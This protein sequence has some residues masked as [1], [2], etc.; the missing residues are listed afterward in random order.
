MWRPQ[1]KH[2]ARVAAAL[3]PLVLACACADLPRD[4]E[5]TL[6]RVR[7]GTLRVGGVDA[8]PWIVREGERA[9]GPEAEL[10]EAFARSLGAR[11]EWRW[12]S[13]DEHMHALERFEL[14][15]VA[16]GL[17]QATPW[18]TRVAL[19]RPWLRRPKE[20]HVL[21]AP[22]GENGIL[23]TLGRYIERTAATATT[24]ARR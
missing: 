13:Q 24:T 16:A 5:G 7:G 12:A 9:T 10:V 17:T 8:P 22:P 18:R 23:T 20:R 4:P 19:T 15:L 3:W 21:A 11:V 2:S 1:G 6:D 14:D